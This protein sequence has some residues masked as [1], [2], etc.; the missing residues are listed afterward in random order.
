MS[1][2]T[3][4]QYIES[5]FSDNWGST[6]PIKW[7]NIEFKYTPNQAFV[8]LEIVS[9]NIVKIDVLTS[10]RY[11]GLITIIINVP[12]N[13]GTKVARTYADTAA[14]I[15]RDKTFDGIVCDSASINTLGGRNEWYKILVTIPFYRETTY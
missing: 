6:T 9:A 5:R 2:S 8:E 10:Y 1:F 4:R 12:I 7:N 11:T 14:T 13:T 3:E 15:F